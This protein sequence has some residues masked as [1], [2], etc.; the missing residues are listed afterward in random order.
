MVVETHAMHH[1]PNTK[2]VLCVVLLW[3]L[4]STMPNRIDQTTK[5]PMLYTQ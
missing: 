2:R 3:P 4:A 5:H 1:P